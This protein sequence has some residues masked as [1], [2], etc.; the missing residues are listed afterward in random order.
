[1][2]PLVISIALAIAIAVVGFLWSSNRSLRNV[3]KLDH[4]LDTKEREA[5]RKL[6]VAEAVSQREALA[7]IRLIQK[8][9]RVAER[10]QPKT[11]KSAIDEARK[12]I[13]EVLD[14]E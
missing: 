8:S 12:S 5:D 11:P 14:E 9:A 1:M 13:E 10:R 7:R 6:R 3:L 4:E 2:I